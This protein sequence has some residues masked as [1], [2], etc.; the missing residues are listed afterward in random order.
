MLLFHHHSLYIVIF[1]GGEF[2]T[3]FR[4]FLS[5]DKYRK[6]DF[7]VT[8]TSA[9]RLVSYLCQKC[10]DSYNVFLFCYLNVGLIW[11]VCRIYFYINRS[12]T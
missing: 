9:T 11:Y 5:I 4:I 3:I 1:L 7:H 12:N 8:Y 2:I 10:N 6:L